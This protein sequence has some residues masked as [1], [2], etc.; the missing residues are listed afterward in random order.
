MKNKLLTLLDLF[1]TIVWW[2]FLGRFNSNM[3]IALDNNLPVYE[4]L[5]SRQMMSWLQIFFVLGFIQ[6]VI[7]VLPVVKAFQQE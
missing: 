2:L 3:G 6:T 4:A 7:S 5:S 1:I